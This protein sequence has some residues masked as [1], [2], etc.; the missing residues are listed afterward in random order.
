M[1]LHED[2]GK[3]GPMYKWSKEVYGVVQLVYVF[4][5]DTSFQGLCALQGSKS[6]IPKVLRFGHGP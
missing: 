5:S 3:R 2:Y 4:G 1:L 6:N